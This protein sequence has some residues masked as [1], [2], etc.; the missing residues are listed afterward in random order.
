M[1]IAID[2]TNAQKYVGCADCIIRALT[3]AAKICP[4]FDA[5]IIADEDNQLSQAVGFYERAVGSDVS[6]GLAL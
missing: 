2:T 5:K 1:L 4:Q 6:I 3:A